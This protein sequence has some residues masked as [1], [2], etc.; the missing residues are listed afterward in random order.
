VNYLDHPTIGTLLYFEPIELEDAMDKIA[1]LSM[2]PETGK[3][4]NYDELQ[5]T[6]ELSL[7]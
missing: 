1:L 2:M 7:K 5:S 6:N 4:L 3:S